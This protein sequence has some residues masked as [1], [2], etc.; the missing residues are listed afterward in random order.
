MMPV[1]CPECGWP[2]RETVRRPHRMRVGPLMWLSIGVMLVGA[3]LLMNLI[4]PWSRMP[5]GLVFLG[6]VVVVLYDSI[7][8]LI[9]RVAER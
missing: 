3:F 8:S 6:A 9:P 7:R 4:V 5:A 2:G 1:R